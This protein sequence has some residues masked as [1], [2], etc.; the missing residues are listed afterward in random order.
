MRKKNEETGNSDSAQS[1]GLVEINPPTSD[2]PSETCGTITSSGKHESS[3]CIPEP[4][5][6]SSSGQKHFSDISMTRY[7][8]LAQPILEIYPA[9]TSNGRKFSANYYKT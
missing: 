7:D 2:I 1:V 6:G 4:L 9:S 5:A 3:V 8:K